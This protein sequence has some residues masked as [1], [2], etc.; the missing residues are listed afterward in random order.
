MYLDSLLLENIKAFERVK[1]DFARPNE[2]DEHE[3]AGLNFF[4]GGNSSGKSTLLKCIAMGLSG[5]AIAN[6]QLI[7]SAGW[8]RRGVS[9][10]L[11]EVKIYSDPKKDS[12]RTKGGTPGIDNT[13]TAGIT[14]EAEK[15]GTPI[16]KEKY[17][18]RANRTKI[19]TAERGPWHPD[20]KGWFL[21]SYAIG[22]IKK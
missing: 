20:T 22:R 7:T 21:A 15:G 18:Q 14:F 8:L 5:P 2:E 19:R 1:L 3:Y 12:F 11:I 6:Q 16:L 10:G 4:V 13:F 9:K 17:Y